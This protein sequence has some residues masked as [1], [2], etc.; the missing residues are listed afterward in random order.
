MYANA[1]GDVPLRVGG[2][3]VV[4]SKDYEHV[5]GS[6]TNQNDCVAVNGLNP[7]KLVIVAAK[8]TVNVSAALFVL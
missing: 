6:V 3:I 7:F 2:I 1:P 4:R 5:G 8:V